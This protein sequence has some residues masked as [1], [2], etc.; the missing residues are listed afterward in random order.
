FV[1]TFNLENGAGL[2][3][4]VNNPAHWA[5]RQFGLY[6]PATGP[7][8]YG[9]PPPAHNAID[10]A[11]VNPNSPGSFLYAPYQFADADDDGFFDSRWTE[12]VNASD[13]N[14]PLSLLPNDGRFRWFVAAR[15]IDLSS[16]VNVNTATD[17]MYA[18]RA[19]RG[20]S[21]G[22]GT[23]TIA[24]PQQPVLRMG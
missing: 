8:F 21:N 5:D 13:P 4:D 9:S 16:M 6:M 20:P 12:M 17:M 11:G 24:V 7:A 22:V 19:N 15:V 23:G 14:N 2:L 10:P 3:A 18:P 1:P